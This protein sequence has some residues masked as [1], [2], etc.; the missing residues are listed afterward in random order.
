MMGFLR[1]TLFKVILI[2]LYARI[3]IGGWRT[4]SLAK[5]FGLDPAFVQGDYRYMLGKINKQKYCEI[6]IASA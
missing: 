4:P 6:F 1:F 2:Y 3:Y 5:Y